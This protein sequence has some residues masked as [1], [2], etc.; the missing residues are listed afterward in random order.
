MLSTLVTIWIFS[1]I[2]REIKANF[3]EHGRHMKETKTTNVIFAVFF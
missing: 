3:V 2:A 1:K